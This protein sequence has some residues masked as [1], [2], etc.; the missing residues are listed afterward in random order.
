[1][2]IVGWLVA[3]LVA[4]AAS[5]CGGGAT[6]P[7]D[8]FA[9][10]DRFTLAPGEMVRVGGA[11]LR[12]VAVTEDSRC[13]IDVVCIWA[14]Q[15]TVELALG[16]AGGDRVVSLTL[17]PET[18]ARFALP[19]GLEIVLL[20]V[21]PAAVSTAPIAPGAHRATLVLQR[22]A[23]G[24]SG[25]RGTITLGPLC[26]VPR[27]GQPCPD[28]PYIATVVVS[29]GSGEV[30]RV[31]SRG[32]GTY[33]LALSAGRYVVT[34]LGAQGRPSRSAT[35]VDIVLESGAWAVLDITY[36]SGIR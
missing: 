18:E 20:E 7:A 19:N 8:D 33:A 28:R 34:P 24:E 6:L 5:S 17:G 13:P 16:G 21:A 1:M 10:D 22:I 26:P 12:F 25:V 9:P 2:Q 32:D 14:G 27:E 30:A 29:D 3:L 23:R 35:P 4:V 15:V 31:S 36:D 11:E